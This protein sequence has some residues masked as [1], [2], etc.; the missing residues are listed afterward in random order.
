MEMVTLS[1]PLYQVFKHKKAARETTTVIQ[2]WEYKNRNASSTDGSILSRGSKGR[3]WSMQSLEECLKNNKYDSLQ[4]YASCMELNGENIIFL[5]KAMNF[6]KQWDSVFARTGD[7]VQRARM[8]MFRNALSIYVSLVHHGTSNY[9]INVES[10]IYAQLNRLFGPATLL[11][12][13]RRPSTPSSP[14]SAATP[15]DEPTS[16]DP[17]AETGTEYFQMGSLQSPPARRRSFDH[18]SS[19]HIISLDESGNPND[20]LADFKVPPEFDR[21]CFDAA[22]KSIKYMVWTETWQRYNDWY[23]TAGTTPAGS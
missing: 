22:E 11:V 8:A 15:W 18:E 3:M 23:K 14:I 13:S 19:E 10:F 9:P 5:V 7:Q 1:F 17:A 21:N 4:M 20:P 16:A 6:K 2:E 12:A